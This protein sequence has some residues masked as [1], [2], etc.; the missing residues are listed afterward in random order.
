MWRFSRRANR[1]DLAQ[2]WKLHVSATTR[3]ACNVLRIVAPYLQRKGVL[4]KAPW[5]LRDLLR[6]NAGLD[7]NFSQVGKFITVYPPSVGAAVEI[8]GHVHSLTA[9]FAAPAVPYDE[10]LRNGSCVYYR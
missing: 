6:L 4:F 5:S 10:R 1:Q 3:S 9:G 8:A 7:G 2:G